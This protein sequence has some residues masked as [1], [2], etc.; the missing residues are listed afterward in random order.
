M[1]AARSTVG[2]LAAESSPQEATVSAASFFSYTACAAAAAAAAVIVPASSATSTPACLPASGCGDGGGGFGGST[3]AAAGRGGSSFKVDTRPC[4]RED[5]T[6]NEQE[7]AERFTD[8]FCNACGVVLQFESQRI[9]HYKSEKHAQN[10]RFYFQMHG[11]QN[12]VL[13]KKMKM[14]VRNFQVHR[15]E[16]VDRNKF[17]DLCNMIFSSRVV[18][19]SHY[20]GKVHAKKLKQLMEEHDQ[21]SPSG[22][23]PRMGVRI[24]TS[25]ESTFLKPHAV[26]PP[27]GGI[28]DKTM[29]SSS[30]TALDLNNPNKYCKL[31]PASF[32]SPLMAQQHYVGKKHKRSEARKKFVDKI[33]EKPLP[34]KSDANA[35]SMRTYVCH[36]CNI[37]FTSLEMFRS[38]MQGSEHQIKE[39]IVI[40][41]V[42]N[43]KKTQDSYQNESADYIKVQKVRGPEPKTCFRK[44]EESVLETRGY[45]QVIDSRFRHR[46]FEGRLPCETFQA[47]PR[48]CSISQ[49]VENQLPHCLPAHSKK[50][51][52]SFQDEL[53]DYIKVQKARGLDPKTCFRKIRESSMETRGY[54][55]VDSG[56]R[57]RMIEQRFSF[58]TSQTYQRPYNISP[59]ES[60]LH[61]WLPTHSKRTYDSFQ[62]ELE[63]YIKVQKARGLEPKTCFRKISDSSM[64][65]LKYR[66]V[67]DSRPRHRM[68]EQRLPFETFQT[69]PG[70]YSISQAVENQ[71]PHCLPAHDSKQRLDSMT[72]C[73]STRDCVPEKPVPLSLS[74]Q[75]N[76][77]GS[78]SVESEVYKHLSAEDNTTDHQAGHKR[79]HQKRRRHLEEGKEKPE[80]EQSKHK[81]KKSYEDTDLDKDK[82]V[83]E[84][85]REGDKVSVSSGKLKH[86]KKKKSHGVTSEKEERKHKKEKKKSVEEKTEEEMLWDESILGF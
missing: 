85:K 16:V 24:T 3:M 69:Y 4:L 75:E 17:C 50:T 52:D 26:K 20:L 81:R 86:R 82:S 68:F 29:P 84:R 41:L 77:S 64:E 73:Q 63:D 8:N 15:N 36:I 49:T 48:S 27:P 43:S 62:D 42:K 14:D 25:A 23:Q 21:V 28:K 57:Q 7:K 56:P 33:R 55:E 2:P 1:A 40:N 51:Y 10:V 80:K 31:C 44:M 32:N 70:S 61:H 54:R 19:Q 11:E 37:T 53:E 60:Q 67:V 83:R 34:A 65:T 46:M 47:Y 76:N 22:F 74:H 59:V 72:Y 13:G 58:E 71:L 38:H 18:A 5:M 6:W 79:R 12:E 78:Y 35:F 9:S 45:R 30:S 39:A 66:E